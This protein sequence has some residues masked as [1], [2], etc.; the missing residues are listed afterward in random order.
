MTAVGPAKVAATTA[1]RDAVLGIL[2]RRFP[3]LPRPKPPC[4]SLTNRLDRL[5]RKAGLAREQDSDAL[6]HAAEAL[7]LAALIA[8]D[9]AMP[10]LAR[11]LCWRQIYRFAT[12]PGPYDKTAVKLALQPLINL[13]RLHARN[14]DGIAACC[15]HE[16]LLRAAGSRGDLTVDGHTVR[17]SSLIPDGEEQAAI[18]QWLWTV[19]LSDGLR[20][21]CQTGHWA[22][23][24]QQ[25]ARHSGIGRRLLDGRQIA[26]IDHAI[27]G[28]P[29]EAQCL[30]D[31]SDTS[32]DW[33][34]VISACLRVITRTLAGSRADDESA[35]MIDAYLA[36]GSDP[37]HRAFHLRL[38]LTIADLAYNTTQA[39]RAI[40]AIEQ[41]RTDAAHDAYLAR[42]ILAHRSQVTLTDATRIQLNTIVRDAGLG[43]P[44]TV[45][46]L[47]SLMS[48][49][50]QSE[51]GLTA[52]LAQ[53]QTCRAA[54]WPESAGAPPDFRDSKTPTSSTI[55]ESTGSVNL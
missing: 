11:D 22:D 52:Q 32:T 6:L 27:A 1:R 3:L 26:V 33:E 10:Q 42:D 9:C 24:H 12:G 54:F 2:G 31:D 50:H 13:G 35:A 47:E 49:V 25:A 29:D 45:T 18:V 40:A 44:L 15:L 41:L 8:S 23:A 34:H 17:L 16:A 46:N 4:G 39:P 55:D 20:A 38:G 14:G 43:T 5:H 7:N 21:L 37:R 30:L 36:L 28:R 53:F 48:A 51:A 19:F